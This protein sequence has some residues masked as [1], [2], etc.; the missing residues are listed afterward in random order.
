M[1]TSG[2]P[3]WGAIQLGGNTLEVFNPQTNSFSTVPLPQEKSGPFGITT[4]PDGN[5]WF[6]EASGG[7][8]VFNP[9]TTLFRQVPLP[10][11]TGGPLQITRGPDG[12][13]WFTEIDSNKIGVINPATLA[14]TEYAIPS[15]DSQPGGITEGP[16]GN[17]WFVESANDLIGSI[18]PATH[19]IGEY[20]T[21]TA[22]SQPTA[23]TVGPDGNL[24]FTENNTRQI[25]ELNP[26]THKITEFNLPAGQTSPAFISAGPDGDLW[27]TQ[28]GGRELGEIDP[29]THIIT[30]MEIPAA[31]NDNG[32]G[33]NAGGIVALPGGSLWLTQPDHDW[34]GEVVISPVITVKPTSQTIAAGQTVSFTAAATGMPPPAV[35]WEI[36]TDGGN[37]FAPVTDGGSIA[38]GGVFSGAQNGTLTITDPTTALNGSQF[39]AVFNNMGWTPLNLIDAK[40]ISSVAALTVNP[41]L[42]ITPTLPEGEVGVNYD[43]TLTIV[44]S[45]APLSTL[46]IS[47][48]S[49][50]GTGLTLGDISTDPVAG[51]VTIDGIPTGAGSV[52]FS[53]NAADAAGA[54]LF[55][56][57]TVVVNPALNVTGSLTGGVTGQL[58]DGKV[59]WGLGLAPYTMTVSNFDG[60]TTGLTAPI[61]IDDG[62]YLVAPYF[63]RAGHLGFNAE[64]ANPGTATF[65][66]TVR[67][68]AGAVV[69][70][71][72][73]I[74]FAGLSITPTLPDGIAGSNYV[75]TIT[76]GDFSAPLTVLT[77]AVQGGADGLT[78][79]PNLAA[80]NVIVNGTPAAAA[81]VHF[82]VSAADSGGLT[83]SYGYE[84]KVAPA[85]TIASPVLAATAGANYT[86]TI[87]VTGGTGSYPTITISNFADGGTGLAA[88]AISSTASAINISGKPSAIGTVTFSVSVADSADTVAT[89][90]CSIAVNP[91]PSITQ[92]TAHVAVG[93]SIGQTLA[94]TAGTQ[95]YTVFTITSWD[96]GSTGLSPDPERIFNNSLNGYL[97]LG[98]VPTA[99]GTAR[100]TVSGSDAQGVQVRA[101]S[102]LRWTGSA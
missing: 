45:T 31:G 2:S 87:P 41:V 44:G 56:T 68:S 40:A 94:M 15:A 53:V 6:T 38:T 69:T 26:A 102:R 60:G 16:D 73:S 52:T 77:V 21:P 91:P 8:G 4:G 100:F 28:E 99:A 17:L 11:A 10:T 101:T 14:I 33:I 74:P 20:A 63:N 22:N 71:N 96:P 97:N 47:A 92:P 1:A 66:V 80:G 27:F 24:W 18:N 58:Y 64:A 88:A 55:M 98:G 49:D 37:T 84:I 9:K 34:I 89:T 54:P 59:F 3:S 32:S 95:P 79:T 43:Q 70:Q 65:T 39:E 50:G 67:D 61:F 36:S 51:T 57:N 25:G 7:I 29:T 48:F 13:L 12:N 85:L 42:K 62:G 72:Y 93:S 75:H 78:F 46:T 19:A 83:L 76:I 90:N 23:I 5:I 30:E 86:A 35:Q 82:S 81:T